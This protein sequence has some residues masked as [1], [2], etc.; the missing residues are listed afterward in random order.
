MEERLCW[1]IV[2]ERV[3]VMVSE[4][5]ILSREIIF[6]RVRKSYIK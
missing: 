6:L 1:F 5:G 4:V 2:L 3:F